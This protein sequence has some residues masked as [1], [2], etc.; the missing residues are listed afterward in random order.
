MMKRF[1]LITFLAS[2]AYFIQAQD[3]NIDSLKRQLT[4]TNK[5]DYLKTLI[6]L[7]WEYRFVNADTARKYGLQGLVLAHEMKID[8]LEADALNYIGITHEAQGNYVQA[9]EYELKA[10][11]IR[12]EIGNQIKI[13]RTLNNIGIIYD[14][15]GNYQKSLEY[16]FEARKIFEQAKDLPKVAMVINN[17][18]IVLKAQREYKKVVGY[19]HEA[20]TIYKTL[21]NKFGIAACHANL[22]SVYL[23]WGKYDSSLFYSIK[24]QNEFEVMNNKQFLASTYTNLGKAYY[25]TG[26]NVEALQALMRAKSLNEEYD[27]K[28]ELAAVLIY[29]ANIK[30]SMHDYSTGIRY[31]S[32]ALTMAD[33]IGARQEMMEA[34][35]ELALLSAGT[36]E[37]RQAFSYYQS[38]EVLKDSLFEKEKAKQISELQ[39]KYETEKK[40]VTINLLTKENEFKDIRLRQVFLAI[41]VLA[42]LLLALLTV[43]LL[44]RNR[45]RLK[46][47]ASLEAARA[48][49]RQQ[50]LQ[51]VIASQEEERKRFAADLHDG[52]GQM[53]SA[54]RMGLSK[55]NLDQQFIHYSLD[56]LNSMNVEIRNIA[57][58]LM[59]QVLMK[60]GLHEALKEFSQRVTQAGGV[61]VEAQTYN[62]SPTMSSEVRIA[63][64]R[65]CQEWVNNVIKYSQCKK[66]VI[67]AVQHPEEL[68]ITIEDDGQGFD[69]NLLMKG[70]GNGWKNINSR[71]SMIL[72][73]IEIDSQP[74]RKGS[75]LMI[76]IPTEKN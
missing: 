8:S 63:L 37:Y 67:Q 15:M 13:G 19:Y 36:K 20:L 28:K 32:Q 72:G 33:K 66:I 30:R 69:R 57:F 70:Q 53:I 29:L 64:Y 71:L 68:V 56:L 47:K 14:E 25:S 59:P 27:N 43:G 17:I 46:Q 58:N 50:Q 23:N 38:Y 6:E 44:V 54:L 5:K 75:M 39:T 55:E 65:I 35:K 49:L 51:A 40:Q 48:E 9:L 4:T 73:S 52:L 24:A 34:T 60:D 21:Q 12:Q 42:L 7:C 31:A 11:A 16:Y 61:Y 76:S 3:Q 2:A 1:I 45:N 22:G 10:L 74:D 26:K 62:L 18:G 41:T